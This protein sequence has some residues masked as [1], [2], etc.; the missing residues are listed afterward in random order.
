MNGKLKKYQQHLGKNAYGK[1]HYLFCVSIN[2][3]AKKSIRNESN[4]KNA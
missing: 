1:N 2:N 4:S 3:S